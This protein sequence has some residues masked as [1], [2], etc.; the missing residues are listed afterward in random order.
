MPAVLPPFVLVPVAPAV[1]PA[2]V[3]PAPVAPAPLDVI[4]APDCMPVE[5]P[6]YAPLLEVALPDVPVCIGVTTICTRLPT[7]P[8]R[9]TLFWPGAATT[10]YGCEPPVRV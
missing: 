1:E 2:P 10:V 3:V 4:P 8:A 7:A 9:S 6:P 5:L